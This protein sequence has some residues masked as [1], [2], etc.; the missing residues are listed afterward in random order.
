[1]SN[2][3]I[4]DATA[5]TWTSAL[6]ASTVE[7]AATGDLTFKFGIDAG[8]VAQDTMT[9][10]ASFPIFI[11]DGNTACT[12]SLGTADISGTTSCATLGNVLTITTTAT[13]A[14]SSAVVVVVTDNLKVNA[15]AGNAVTFGAESSKDTDALATQVGYSTT[16]TPPPAF[17]LCTTI[18]SLTTI[19]PVGPTYTGV[20]IADASCA[21]TACAA[22]D[23]A[24]CCAVWPACTGVA[25]P[26]D[27]KGCDNACTAADKPY[28]GCDNACTSSAILPYDGCT[29]ATC[30]DD[31]DTPYPGCLTTPARCESLKKEFQSLDCSSTC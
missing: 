22:S 25:E 7:N 3:G 13:M 16:P 24:A 28:K 20:L 17:A 1:M 5:L 23:A 31:A 11:A 14:G 18:T 4:A 29:V 12:V 21:G 19:C 26:T 9:L 6:P 8:L 10:T 15:G 27:S 30:T 2:L